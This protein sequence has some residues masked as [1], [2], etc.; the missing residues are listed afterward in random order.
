MSTVV[1]DQRLRDYAELAVR[2]G[3][4][5]KSGQRLIIRGPVEGAPL[6]RCIADSAYKAGARLVEV[7]W[8]D[9]DLTLSRFRHAPRDSFEE[10]PT[11][12]AKAQLEMVEHGDALLVVYGADPSLLKEQNSD[13][14][15]LVMRTNQKHMAPVARKISNDDTNWCVIGVPIPGWASRVFPSD[16]SEKALEKLWDAVFRVCRLDQPDPVGAWQKHLALLAA[17][18]EHLTKKQFRE[19]HYTGPGTDLTVGL[20]KDHIWR[21]GRSTTPSGITFTANL[22]TEETWS[23]P[24]R[25][26]VDGVITSTKP[27]SYAGVLIERLKLTFSGG[28]VTEATADNGADVLR[29]LIATDDGAARL[30]EVALVPHSSGVSQTGLL[31]FDTLYDENAS[32]HFALGRAYRNCVAAGQTM[33][34]EQFAAAGGNASLVHVDFMVGSPSLNIDGITKEGKAEPVMRAGEWAF[35]L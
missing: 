8:F 28:R 30:G 24:Q 9:D 4:G 14:V 7:L 10:Y 18:S 16:P 2:V 21:S 25:D 22:P 19:L 33:T 3:L 5:L 12:R 11:W 35:K 34:D 1:S 20:P 26:R 13:L 27:L 31:F 17:R 32:C 29:Q 23:M 6:V 15:S